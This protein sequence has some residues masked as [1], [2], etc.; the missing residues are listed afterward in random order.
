MFCVVNGRFEKIVS[1]KKVSRR[2]KLIV[3]PPEN[4]VFQIFDGLGPQILFQMLSLMICVGV[5]SGV[6]PQSAW[7]P[8]YEQ[9]VLE[10]T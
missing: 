3:A 2:K 7:G 4:A 1:D 6:W 9:K 10:K 8:S 5:A